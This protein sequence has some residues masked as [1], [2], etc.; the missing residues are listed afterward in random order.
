MLDREKIIEEMAVSLCKS[1]ELPC[2]ATEKDKHP[3]TIDNCF[4]MQ[5]AEAALKALCRALPDVTYYSETPLGSIVG[6]N[7]DR[8]YM[9]LKSWGKECR[10]KE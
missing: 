7:A 5:D 8:L 1:R 2:C 3:C 10:S 6:D 4:S 9:E